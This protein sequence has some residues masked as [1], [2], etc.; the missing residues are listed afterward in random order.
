MKTR[1][2][3]R[4]N[5][6]NRKNR[7]QRNSRNSRK[8]LAFV[9]KQRGGAFYGGLNAVL[10]TTTW[11]DWSANPASTSWGPTTQAPPPL[12]NGGLF[13]APQSTGAWASIPMPATQH[14]FALEAAKVSGIPEVAY[15]QSINASSPY[16]HAPLSPSHYSAGIPPQ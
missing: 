6:N 7:K 4:N 11:G 1:R 9:R 15:H 10:P 5:R 13:N 2:N 12:A 8:G 3:N 16:V 14:A